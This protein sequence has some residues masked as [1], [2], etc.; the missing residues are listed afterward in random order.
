MGEI[1]GWDGGFFE[2]EYSAG[3]LLGLVDSVEKYVENFLGEGILV[4]FC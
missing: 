3:V 1:W 4:G 2:N